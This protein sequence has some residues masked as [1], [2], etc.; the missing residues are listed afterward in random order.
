MVKAYG[1]A[2]VRYVIKSIT[3]YISPPLTLT[4][5]CPRESP[6]GS[7]VHLLTEILPIVIRA[8]DESVVF[9]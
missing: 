6:F 4:L 2:V 7:L 3:S 8:H 1:E 9:V 5:T